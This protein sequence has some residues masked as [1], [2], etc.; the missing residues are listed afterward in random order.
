VAKTG[1][2]GTKG[3]SGAAAGE[4]GRSSSN[5][6]RARPRFAVGAPQGCGHC[7]LAPL[8]GC[9]IGAV[10]SRRHARR[11]SANS[12]IWPPGPRRS[13]RSPKG[14]IHR[15]EKV[16]VVV[17]LGVLPG[18]DVKPRA[19]APMVE[20]RRCAVGCDRA[21]ITDAIFIC[22]RRD[23]RH[24]LSRARRQGESHL[25]AAG[26]YGKLAHMACGRGAKKC[27]GL[28]RARRRAQPDWRRDAKRRR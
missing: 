3:V 23:A 19:Q 28:L 26:L 2:R 9:G 22:V 10:Q 4:G 12:V 20:L 27:H 15:R 6:G 8:T 21:R 14:L 25:R 17:V 1:S 5:R 13:G 11:Q 18:I 16:S 7:L 24:L